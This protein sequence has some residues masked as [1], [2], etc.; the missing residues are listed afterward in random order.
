MRRIPAHHLRALRNSVAV[1]D[2]IAH[3][4][5][6][7][8]KSG[9]RSSFRCPQCGGYPTAI[10]PATNLARCF[11]C[12]KSFNP[13]ELVMAERHWSFLEAVRYLET[14][15]GITPVPTRD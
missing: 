7:T 11:H 1:L 8:R 5:I 2:V 13:I 14:T 12:Q 6:P 15:H 10:N 3:L 9:A 4:G